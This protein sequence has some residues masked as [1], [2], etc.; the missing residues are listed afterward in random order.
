ML[1]PFSVGIVTGCVQSAVGALQ[2]SPG[3]D[4]G[5]MRK[6]V[7]L[8]L[9]LPAV[10]TCPVL[11]DGVYRSGHRILK[12]VW[13][14]MQAYRRIAHSLLLLVVG[15]AVPLAPV[16]AQRTFTATAAAML[17]VDAEYDRYRCR[18]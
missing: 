2:F 8:T 5:E 1:L 16:D 12:A 9:H 4:S 17:E 7:K 18:G 6:A 3:A 14:S 11:F 13:F 10:R 15:A